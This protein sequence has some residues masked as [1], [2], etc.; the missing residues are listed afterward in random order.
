[1]TTTRPAVGITTWI[2][3][4]V[5]RGVAFTR[6]GCTGMGNP[7]RGASLGRKVDAG[8]KTLCKTGSVP[9]N[10]EHWALK[11][12]KAI[13]TTLRKAGVTLVDANRF[14]KMGSLKTH[15]DG[16]GT[17]PDGSPVVIELK[18]TQASLSNHRA[19]YDVACSALPSVRIGQSKA[20][21]TERI[22]HQLQVNFGVHA[23]G[24]GCRHG[25]VVVSASD[26]AIAYRATAG[27]PASV[28]TT[29]VPVRVAAAAAARPARKRGKRA[30]VTKGYRWPGAAVALRGVGWEDAARVTT[31]VTLLRHAVTGQWGIATATTGGRGKFEAAK[32]RLRAAD[33]LVDHPVSKRIVVMPGARAWKCYCV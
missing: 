15:I 27:I 21:N 2:K 6:V 5:L 7:T 32:Q 20:P 4:T 19:A 28:Y 17:M 10:C 25:F 1:M 22:H 8:F 30:Q 23:L 26:G 11:R 13:E 31:C 12:L 33:R 24:G 14:V 9:R 29:A 18:C 3:S 16:I